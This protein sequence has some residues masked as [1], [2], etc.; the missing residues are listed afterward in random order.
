MT[1]IGKGFIALFSMIAMIIPTMMLSGYFSTNFMNNTGTPMMYI[2]PAEYT[3]NTY[4]I[5]VKINANSQDTITIYEIHINNKPLQ[6]YDPQAL[7][8]GCD[9]ADILPLK[10]I[11]NADNIVRIT[12]K[13]ACAG[14]FIRL[15][16]YTSAGILFQTIEI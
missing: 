14:Q 12:L 2:Y 10:I 6:E 15:E 9:P 3:G 11:S 1:S 13:K 16:I 5:L 7:I 8:N 4:N